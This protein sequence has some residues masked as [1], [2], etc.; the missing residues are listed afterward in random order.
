[1]QVEFN[2]NGN[3]KQK[4]C[5]VKWNDN[6]T[7]EIVYG[8]SKGSGKTYLGCQLI[9]GHALTYSDTR[10]FIARKKLKD[11][12]ES[13]L[14]TIKLVFNHWGINFDDYVKFN[15]QYNT[16]HLKNGSRVVFKDAK[17]QP[18]DPLYARFGSLTYTMGWIEEA[19]EFEYDCS[20]NLKISVGRW[21]NKK[22]NITGKVLETCNP[23]KNY[24]YDNFY[25]P[26]K[27]GI[28]EP[29][30]CFIQALPTDNKMLDDGYIEEMERTL[31]HN[32]KQRL[33]YGNWEYDDN[34]YALFDYE[35]ILK[36]YTNEV[37]ETSDEYIT[38]DIAYTG[39]DKFVLGY[40]KGLVL[41]DIESIDKI[42]QSLVSKKIHEFRTKLVKG[43]PKRR[44]P[45]KNVIY[46]ADGLKMFVIQSAKTGY[47]A[48]A[49]QFHNGGKPIKIKG[50][51]ENF[52][53]LKTQ[54]S[55]KLSEYVRNNKIRIETKDYRDEI[56]KEFEQILRNPLKDGERISQESK[57]K[58]RERLG[59]SPDY[60]DMINMRMFFEINKRSYTNDTSWVSSFI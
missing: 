36:M 56:V 52:S 3:E 14:P 1:M 7:K 54:C 50:Q 17:Y 49:L 29:E 35:D 53:N 5:C 19:G 45:I 31:N 24:L 10:Y 27:Q 39:A 6:I 20:K 55:F 44:V 4:L 25:L 2:T 22:Y 40:W 23:A 16:F 32:E 15:G 9:F 18:S 60:Y 28:I 59:R 46:D 58:V 41:K 13:T 42:D 47:L 8:G 30:R 57:N 51:I 26:D 38:A 33:L 43:E 12:I 37:E 21:N 34:P 11:L 48:G